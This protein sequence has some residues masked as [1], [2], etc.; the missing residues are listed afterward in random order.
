VITKL[1][2]QWKVE[3]RAFAERDL[4]GVDLRHGAAPDEG[5][6]GARLA[7]GW[8]GDGVQADRVGPVP[9]ACGQ[10]PTPGRA[11]ARFERSVLVEREEDTAA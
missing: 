11:G 5:D 8:A 1:T 4:S 6:Q 9:L 2:E 3:Q 10:R 7:S